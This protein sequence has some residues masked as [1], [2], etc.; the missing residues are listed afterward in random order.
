[1]IWSAAVTIDDD[2]SLV[3]EM[4]AGGL[5]GVFVGFESLAGEAWSGSKKT[6]ARRLRAV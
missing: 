3:R 4:A 6:P 1:V 2:P 5:H